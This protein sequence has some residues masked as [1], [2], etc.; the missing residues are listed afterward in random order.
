MVESYRESL[1]H[2]LRRSGPENPG[3]LPVMSEVSGDGVESQFDA[4]AA[5]PG[6][7]PAHGLILRKVVA[8]CGKVDEFHSLSFTDVPNMRMAVEDRFHL[9]MGAEDFKQAVRVEQI[10]IAFAKRM[11]HE[12][13]R[14]FIGM[15][16][17]VF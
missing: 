11:V 5:K 16:L 10:A 12:E 4:V 14:W 8:E 6:I 15:R 2:C 9:A 1:C 13:N 3:G 7:H 17:E